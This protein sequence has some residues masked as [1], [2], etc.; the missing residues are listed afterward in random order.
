[1][2]KSGD[3]VLG[4]HP[5]VCGHPKFPP[6]RAPKKTLQK[7]VFIPQGL[8]SITF[9]QKGKA[10][11]KGFNQIEEKYLSIPPYTVNEEK[12]FHQNGTPSVP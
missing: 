1:M 2:I 4:M 12:G 11:E 7:N 10:L 9:I 5:N 6:I 3:Q 8:S